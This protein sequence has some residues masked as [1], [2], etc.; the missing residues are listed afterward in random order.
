MVLVF[1][2]KTGVHL[3]LYSISHF[4]LG[5]KKFYLRGWEGG[6]EAEDESEG[7]SYNF[8]KLNEQLNH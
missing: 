3:L 8:P 1:L 4:S 6:G 2:S 5:Q 7:N